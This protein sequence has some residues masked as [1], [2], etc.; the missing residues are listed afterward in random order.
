[1]TLSATVNLNNTYA[2]LSETDTYTEGNLFRIS[3]ESG[4]GRIILSYSQDLTPDSMTN[5][6]LDMTKG[7]T[8]PT[9]TTSLENS[10]TLQFIAKLLKVSDENNFN[11]EDQRY[12]VLSTSS[13]F[14]KDLDIKPSGLRNINTFVDSPLTSEKTSAILSFSIHPRVPASPRSPA[15]VTLDLDPSNVSIESNDL[16]CKS[17]ETN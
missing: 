8:M 4:V 2:E 9:S 14:K 15:I 12:Q 1:M 16:S 10:R 5:M 3:D 6:V 17:P 11:L 7:L 13:V